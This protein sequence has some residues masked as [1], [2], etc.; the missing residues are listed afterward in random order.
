[1][2]EHRVY[3]IR[4]PKRT[5]HAP[6]RLRN[7]G[8]LEVQVG[9]PLHLAPELV[10]NLREDMVLKYTCHSNAIEG[11]TLTLM[12]AKVVL[13][14]G[15]TIGGKPLRHHLEAINHADAITCL[16]GLVQ[17]DVSLDDAY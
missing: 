5:P 1:M 4:K 8:R 11:N 12:E 16:E 17:E 14:E 7:S 3:Q 13:E 6:W 9:H 2:D 15:L 10:R